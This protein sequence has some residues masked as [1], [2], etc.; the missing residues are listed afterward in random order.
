MRKN[1]GPRGQL[2][3]VHEVREH[4]GH[5]SHNHVTLVRHGHP[6]AYAD[7]EL[8]LYQIIGDLSRILPMKRGQKILPHII[9]GL[10]TV[11]FD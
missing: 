7:G 11:D 1:L 10:I 9:N 5:R 6:V 8:R 4:L 3:S 2:H